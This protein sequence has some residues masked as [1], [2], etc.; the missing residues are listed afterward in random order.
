MS[1]ECGDLCPLHRLPRVST[2]KLQTNKIQFELVSVRWGSGVRC[3]RHT[4]PASPWPNLSPVLSEKLDLGMLSLKQN[5]THSSVP[6]PKDIG[7]S[8]FC[9]QKGVAMSWEYTLGYPEFHAPAW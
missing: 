3:L 2:F 6:T 8:L 4:V 1:E 9:S 5:K 7:D